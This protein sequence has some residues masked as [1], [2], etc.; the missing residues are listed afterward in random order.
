MGKF[1]FLCIFYGKKLY[2]KLF[3]VPVN[4]SLIAR[5]W[6]FEPLTRFK[7]LA[8]RPAN[9]PMAEILGRPGQRLIWSSATSSNYRKKLLLCLIID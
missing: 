4:C 6:V 8:G 7:S 1:P 5:F 3:S 2:G 9:R